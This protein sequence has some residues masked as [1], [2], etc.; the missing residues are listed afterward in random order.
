MEGI[1]TNGMEDEFL[2]L[3]AEFKRV[4]PGPDRRCLEQICEELDALVERLQ[5][6][7][8]AASAMTAWCGSAMR[9][10]SSS[11]PRSS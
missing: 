2:D 1:Q 11:V 10:A 4:G 9:S 8:T 3:L 5:R 6:G 7:C